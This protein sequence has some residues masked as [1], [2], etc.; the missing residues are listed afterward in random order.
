M[1]V[2]FA[3]PARYDAGLNEGIVGRLTQAIRVS[4]SKDGLAVGIQ[5]VYGNVAEE[6]EKAEAKDRPLLIYSWL[7][8]AEIMTHGRFVRITLE[9]FYHCGEKDVVP[10]LAKPLVRGVAA[11]DFPVEQV[12]KAVVWRLRQPSATNVALFVDKFSLSAT[13]LQELLKLRDDISLSRSSDSSPVSP[14]EIACRWLNSNTVEWEAWL[15][16]S[17]LYDTTPLYQWQ[18]W[19][20]ACGVCFFVVGCAACLSLCSLWRRKAKR[21]ETAMEKGCHGF[22]RC[23]PQL[24]WKQKP[25]D[26]EK[27]KGY[28]RRTERKPFCP[29]KGYLYDAGKC[30]FIFGFENPSTGGKLVL[31]AIG[32]LFVAASSGFFKILLFETWLGDGLN[33]LSLEVTISCAVL[34]LTLELIEWALVL[35]PS[36]EKIVRDQLQSKLAKCKSPNDE[37]N[38]KLSSKLASDCYMS[39]VELVSSLLGIVFATG[40]LFYHTFKNGTP[41]DVSDMMIFAFFL[42]PMWLVLGSVGSLYRMKSQQKIVT[43]ILPGQEHNAADVISYKQA[44]SGVMWITVYL[45]WA[46][47]PIFMNPLINDLGPGTNSAL[48][49]DVLTVS[50]RDAQ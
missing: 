48:Q 25:E 27:K 17:N 46:L 1:C 43:R 33:K 37:K 24:P 44:Y 50:T 10:L 7:P 30:L 22:L 42:G 35:L 4:I 40:F 13:Q 18:D 16:S 49:S 8:R 19:L 36:G 38:K 14:D 21:E 15:P 11:C 23:L 29:L 34:M 20:V 9:S 32:Q 12:E 28:W 6:V 39:A 45:L 31:Y 26:N 41:Q 3:R 47:A 5:I 2:H